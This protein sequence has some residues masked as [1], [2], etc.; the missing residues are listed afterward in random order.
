MFTEEAIDILGGEG[1]QDVL[2]VQQFEESLIET[3]Q[4]DPDIATCYNTYLEARR[5]L[6]DKAKS[7]GFWPGHSSGK[8]KGGKFSK[9]GKSK[10][11]WRFRKPLAQRIME[12][13]CKRC[14]QKGHWK[15]ECPLRFAGAA[16][17][18]PNPQPPAKENAAFAGVA[19]VLMVEP[20]E[21]MIVCE[22][23]EPTENEGVTL[24]NF[25][26]KD[27]VEQ[28]ICYLGNEKKQ[29]PN[30]SNPQK[31]RDLPQNLFQPMQR[32]I[33]SLRARL[34]SITSPQ[35]EKAVDVC[36]ASQGPC[37][38]V[39]LGASQ[40]VIGQKQV[41]D[42]LHSLPT[43]LQAKV[44]KIDCNT[45]FRFGNS[46]T[47]SCDHALLFPL[48]RWFVKV[49]VVRS[50]TPFL[51]SNNVF[52]TLKAL[53]D[54]DGD[55]VIFRRLGFQMP[56]T[57]SGRKLYLLDFCELLQRAHE[58]TIAE[59]PSSC[60]I[61]S[62]PDER[63]CMTCVE[64]AL[65]GDASQ[66]RNEMI[67]DP[68]LCLESKATD[69]RKEQDQCL[70]HVGRDERPCSEIPAVD[71][72]PKGCRG[73]HTDSP[74]GLPGAGTMPHLIRG[75]THGQDNV[76]LHCDEM[77]KHLPQNTKV[78]HGAQTKARSRPS[79]SMPHAETLEEEGTSE[80]DSA[81]WDLVQEAEFSQQRIH[82]LES[83]LAQVIEQV[84]ALTQLQADQGHLNTQPD[85]P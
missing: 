34:R 78:I 16:G 1:D 38:I 14:F 36:F 65:A 9:G 17:T 75:S 50:D 31:L 24:L 80:A 48:S 23:I 51:L 42:L 18:S 28:T 32:L 41:Q 39:D 83:A 11:S 26:P 10:G 52:R 12:S 15:A 56:L 82:R 60:D 67:V 79:T 45:V 2:V 53:I 71:H 8:G 43:A 81:M 62:K 59:Q 44:K 30:F 55:T 49:C 64:D 13:E 22:M 72:S 35:P 58:K 47:V 63:S 40:S 6:S 21:D 84:Q 68:Q 54:T 46:S 29:N 69:S 85:H 19:E 3:I 61:M 20:E 4:S 27:V 37:G 5:R 25:I 73:E 76:K 66:T 57:L 7:R 70:N 74:D 33:P 77:E